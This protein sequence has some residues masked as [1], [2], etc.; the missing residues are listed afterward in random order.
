[1]NTERSA[2]SNII[3]ESRKKLYLTGVTDTDSFD[4]KEAVLFTVCGGLRIKGSDLK[5]VKLS[6][7]E[8]EAIIEG[9]IDSLAYSDIA[10]S[11][12][13]SFFTR[14]FK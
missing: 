4:E 5:I 12:K 3:C 1:M 10:D 9:D 8:G 13:E 11:R 2:Q 7:E 14:L 6:V